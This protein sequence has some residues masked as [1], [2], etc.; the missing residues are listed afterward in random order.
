MKQLHWIFI[1]VTNECM[2]IE[3]QN[4]AS[5]LPA[6]T[7]LCIYGH[8]LK[9]APVNKQYQPRI[10]KLFVNLGLLSPNRELCEPAY[11]IQTKCPC[12]CMSCIYFVIELSN[13][14]LSVLRLPVYIPLQAGCICVHITTSSHT[15]YACLYMYVHTISYV[16]KA[17]SCAILMAR[18]LCCM[19]RK[20]NHCSL[21]TI[22]QGHSVYIRICYSSQNIRRNHS[23]IIIALLSNVQDC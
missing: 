12:P 8:F 5:Q 11:S 1:A 23:H 16:H 13:S 10:N 4:D 7:Q 14:E 17:K 9:C 21:Q 19:K 20:V 22:I 15:L 18:P 2:F 6:P 3:L